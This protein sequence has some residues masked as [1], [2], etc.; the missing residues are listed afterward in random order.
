MCTDMSRAEALDRSEVDITE[1]RH[2]GDAASQA[3]HA[4]VRHRARRQRD[5]C[6]ARIRA[7]GP[8]GLTNNE[9]LDQINAHPA[10]GARIELHQVTPRTSELKRA[11]LIT[12]SRREPTRL[13]A[14]GN[15]CAV[16]VA[17]EHLC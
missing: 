14:A 12:Q 10:S 3:A 2:A 6:L 1:G 15:A 4:R 16:L 8:A 9:L 13:N 17:V 7:A 5:W 11:G